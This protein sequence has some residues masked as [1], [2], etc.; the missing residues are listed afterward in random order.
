M[1][2]IIFYINVYIWLICRYRVKKDRN[3]YAV[4]ALEDNSNLIVLQKEIAFQMRSECL[5][6]VDIYD[7][8]YH[9]SK[10]WVIFSL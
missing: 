6:I 8:Y 4:K 3:Y 1:L 10:L 9:D 7:T 2:C 5:N